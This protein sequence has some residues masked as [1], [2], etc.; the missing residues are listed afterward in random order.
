MSRPAP[1]TITAR[2]SNATDMMNEI[3]TPGHTPHATDFMSK[4]TVASH[5]RFFTAYLRSGD[6]VLDCGCGPGTMTLGI[7][8]IVAPGMVTGIDVAASQIERAA[9]QAAERGVGNVVFRSASCYALPFEEASFDRVFCHALME[10]LSEPV[11]A[12]REFFRVLKPGGSVGLCSPDWDGLL[13]APPSERL[14]EAAAAYASLQESNGGDLRATSSASIWRRQ[15]FRTFRWPRDTNVTRRSPS[16]GN[17]WRSSWQKAGKPHMLGRFENGVP[18][19]K[20]FSRRPGC[21]RWG[22]KLNSE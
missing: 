21:R 22:R 16:L 6:S 5:G 1:S 10:H 20:V 4:R 15:D 13:L 12:L 9:K 3:Y 14:T 17:T 18:A 8:S 7:A 2:R 11:A 19:R